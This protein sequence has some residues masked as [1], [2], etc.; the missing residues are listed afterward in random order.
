M[1]FVIDLPLCSGFNAIYTCVD[2]LSK[3]VRVTP[4]YLGEGKLSARD[5]ANLFFNIVVCHHGL[6]DDIVHDRDLR[7]TSAF[8]RA[9][10]A[11]LGTKC[12][13]STSHYPQTDGQTERMQR[14]LQQVLRGMVHAEG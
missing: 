12:T 4:C 7:F 5:T 10:M 14:T 8:W 13:F 3:L 6:P 11:R 2:H 9:L 1:D